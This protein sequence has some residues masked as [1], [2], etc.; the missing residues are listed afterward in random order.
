MKSYKNILVGVDL[1]DRHRIVA[2]ER[3]PETKEAV[4]RA[5]WLAK[6]N[7][8]ALSYFSVLPPVAEQLS[9]D[10]QILMTPDDDYKS[11]L[12]H[13]REVLSEIAS[14][15]AEKALQTSSDVQ[16]GRSWIEIIRKVLRDQHDLVVVGTRQ[17]GTF[18]T[19]LYGETGMKLF[20]K[21][22]C[23]VWIAKPQTTDAISPILIAHDL[24]DVGDK[25]LRHAAWFAGQWGSML[26]VLHVIEQP[27]K[28]WAKIPSGD[29]VEKAISERLAE[30]DVAE[31]QFQ[32]LVVE[33]TPENAILNYIDEQAIQLLVMGTVARVGMPGFFLGNTAE[34]LLPFLSCSV[35]AVKP[36]HFQT[37]VRLT[38][39]TSESQHGSGI[40]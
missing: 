18:R 32:I 11:V 33:D 5:E 37:P 29:R 25:A 35:L 9:Y 7:S 22:P 2:A 26:H 36:D 39:E 16:L 4:R 20:R 34:K 27:A 1:A 6:T 13:A 24:T 8:A 28:S 19:L 21:C 3:S 30:L 15:T 31:S 12:E 10:R 40:L 23:P 17:R 38:D 14:S